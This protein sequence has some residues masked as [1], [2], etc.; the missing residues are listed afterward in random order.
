MAFTVSNDLTTEGTES[1]KVTLDSTD[2]NGVTAGLISTITINDTSVTPPTST[3]SPTSTPGPTNTPLPS[4]TPTVEP[5][6]TPTESLTCLD[7]NNDN[8]FDIEYSQGPLYVF[9]GNYDKYHTN[10]G[11][12]ILENVSSSHPITVLNNGKENLIYLDGIHGGTK[13]GLDGNSYSYYYGNV[14]ITVQ[15]NYGHVSYEG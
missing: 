6:P 10:T 14:T 2:E 3:P 7:P 12:Y 13:I 11:T 9:N 5:T 4:P 8:P 1:L 15:G